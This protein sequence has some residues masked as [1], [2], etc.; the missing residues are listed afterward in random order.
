MRDVAV[1]GFAQAPL[2]QPPG[3]P[4]NLMLLPVVA[5]ALERSG[6]DRSDIGFTCSGSADYLTGGVF[7]FVS[8]LEAAGAW[9][10]ISESHVEMDGAWAL[11]EAWVRLQHGDIDTAL[12]YSSGR[13]T[14]GDL[15]D[16]L[17]LQLDPYYLMPLWPDYV[18]LA[19][20]QAQ[21]VLEAS[22]HTE[23]DL[24]EIAV[25]AGRAAADNPHAVRKGDSRVEDLLATDYVASPLR[26]H[27]I[28][29]VTDGGAAVVLAVGDR[30]SEVCERPAWITGIDHRVD[31]Q[32]PG[33]R[34]LTVSSS[35][36][37]AAEGAGVG[38]GPVEVAELAA[39]FTHE[40]LVLSDALGLDDEV[41]I[42]P[43]GGAL[44]SNPVMVTGLVRI[45]EA[46][47]QVTEGG[48]RRVVAHASSGPCLQQNLVCVMEGA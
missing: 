42:N 41:E 45:G 40:V 23:A 9:P 33:V 25:S 17:V 31:P 7:A 10:P 18:S 48:R 5:E 36:R 38:A 34:D 14:A 11:Y 1:V 15:R 8:T 28:A 22:G 37:L 39:G 12:V 19:A 29:P 20:I 27:D 46:A 16:T 35:A 47:L 24:A 44:A 32:Y 6:I 4:E 2:D 30:A 3:Q 21:A 43:S 26:D 13:A